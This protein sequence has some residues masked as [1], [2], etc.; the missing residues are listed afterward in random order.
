[1][2]EIKMIRMPSSLTGTRRQMKQTNK[3]LSTC[4]KR[5]CLYVE[6]TQLSA[7]YFFFPQVGNTNCDFI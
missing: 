2:V 5:I 6:V 7:V 1:M 4:F 3:K